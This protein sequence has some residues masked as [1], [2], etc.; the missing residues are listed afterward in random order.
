MRTSAAAISWHAHGLL[1]GGPAVGRLPP[2]KPYLASRTWY[3]PLLMAGR[4]R[5]ALHVL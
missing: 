1:T 4:T 5:F 2:P 3:Q